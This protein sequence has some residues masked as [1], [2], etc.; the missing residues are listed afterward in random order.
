M[1]KIE[2]GIAAFFKY[3]ELDLAILAFF[4]H[5]VWEF[6]QVPWYAGMSEIP[7]WEGVIFCSR[8]T[9]G[10][11]FIASV[12]YATI[13]VVA[14]DRYWPQDASK[15]RIGGFLAIGLAVTIALEWLATSKLGRWEY[16]HDMW[17]LPVIGTGIAPILQWIVI[18]VLSVYFLRRLW[19]VDK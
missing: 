13:S 10:D 9:S 18:P 14:R 6:W 4:L 16:A 2:N 11:V 5:F 12:A 7:H 15:M 3:P 17:T 1:R 19:S 8:A